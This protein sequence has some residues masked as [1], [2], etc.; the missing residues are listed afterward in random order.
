MPPVRMCGIMRAEVHVND[1]G[2]RN[3]ALHKGDMV[4]EFGLISWLVKK[5]K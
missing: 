2:R 4:I 5:L 1:I 3:T